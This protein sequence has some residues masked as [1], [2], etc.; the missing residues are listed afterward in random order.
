MPLW[1]LTSRHACA[2]WRGGGGA[3]RAAQGCAALS[4]A[5]PARHRALV[6]SCGAV[7]DGRAVSIAANWNG[8]QAACSRREEQATLGALRFLEQLVMGKSGRAGAISIE[9]H[10]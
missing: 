6:R 9:K 10:R 7:E 3:A 8:N 5:L 2:A 1:A 4:C